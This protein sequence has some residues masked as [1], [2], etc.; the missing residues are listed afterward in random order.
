MDFYSEAELSGI[1]QAT[2]TLMRDRYEGSQ[3]SFALWFG[4]VK[5][6]SLD[7]DSAEIACENK[8]KQTVLT[9]RFLPFIR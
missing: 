2:V 5:L 6:V 3:Q 1:W 4:L 7:A 8:T 9:D